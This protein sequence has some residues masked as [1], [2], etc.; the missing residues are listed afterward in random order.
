MKREKTDKIKEEDTEPLTFVIE[1][2]SVYEEV[3]KKIGVFFY[4]IMFQ[5]VITFGFLAILL[6]SYIFNLPQ[7]SVLELLGLYIFFT[8]LMLYFYIKNR[9]IVD[10]LLDIYERSK[11]F[12]ERIRKELKE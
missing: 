4:I 10:K 5:F 9:K 2:G 1:S 12:E 7:P 3:S 6:G 11:E 8:F